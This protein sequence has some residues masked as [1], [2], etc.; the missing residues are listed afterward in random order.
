MHTPITIAFELFNPHFIYKFEVIIIYNPTGF[1][2]KP[3]NAPLYPHKNK[4][5]NK[6]SS[7]NFKLLGSQSNYNSG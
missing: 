3:S 6:F 1:Y 7:E 2:L 5:I 4:F